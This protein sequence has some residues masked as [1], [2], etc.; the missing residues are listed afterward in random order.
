M[1]SELYFA[2]SSNIT[3]QKY[4]VGLHPRSDLTVDSGAFESLRVAFPAPPMPPS[5]EVFGS[6]LMSKPGL[7]FSPS[8]MCFCG[9]SAP[10]IEVPRLIPHVL[11]KQRSHRSTHGEGQGH[12]QVLT[13]LVPS[14]AVKGMAGRPPP[15][16]CSREDGA[17][18]LWV[19]L[20]L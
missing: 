15:P 16:P 19:G 7:D 3:K 13:P 5:M 11:L 18:S 9:S 14:A 6:F 20:G 10:R 17:S 2:L 1:L 8:M 4:L 12:R